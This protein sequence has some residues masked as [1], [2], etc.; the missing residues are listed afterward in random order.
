MDQITFL[1]FQFLGYIKW[2]D[3]QIL[4]MLFY[5]Y[6]PQS[7]LSFCIFAYSSFS[8]SVYT[9]VENLSEKNSTCHLKLLEA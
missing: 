3:E 4:T 7:L 1:E 6:T 8:P 2:K 9:Q 5:T